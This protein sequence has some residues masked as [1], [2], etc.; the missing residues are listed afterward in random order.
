MSW[1]LFSYKVFKIQ[2]VYYAPARLISDQPHFKGF[3]PPWCMGAILDSTGLA[4][5]TL[6][7]TRPAKR[8]EGNSG[9]SVWPSSA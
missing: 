9:F 3:M 4:S 7:R 1:I 8:A 2:C 6:Q 5:E